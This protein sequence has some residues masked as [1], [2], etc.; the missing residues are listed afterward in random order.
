MRTT[1]KN[2]IE[3][4]LRDYPKIPAYIR[5]K[6]EEIMY[7]YIEPDENVGGGQ[8][9][10]LNHSPVERIVLKIDDNEFISAFK[11]QAKAINKALDTC[12]DSF[13][14]VIESFYFTER[15]NRTI[16]AL[17]EDYGYSPAYIYRERNRFF[18]EILKNLGLSYLA[19]RD[20]ILQDRN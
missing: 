7:P 2:F 18:K 13:T 5:R 19:E 12:D 10:G 3:D 17:G 14:E 16:T 15:C 11:R 6:N 8:G 9:H 20:Q 1:T 4:L